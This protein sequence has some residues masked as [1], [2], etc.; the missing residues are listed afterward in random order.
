MNR[1]I[2]VLTVCTGN[3]CRSPLAAA[4][5]DR[6]LRGSGV[7]VLVQSAGT[8]AFEGHAPPNHMIE[9]ADQFDVDLRNVR[10]RSVTSAALTGADLVLCLAADHARHVLGMA[11][12]I[13][14]R[15][16]LLKEAARYVPAVHDSSVDTPRSST[17]PTAM[18]D[19]FV[20]WRA[21]MVG[22][23]DPMRYWSSES[24]RD[25]IPDPMGHR[26]QRYHDVAERVAF[27]AQLL[28]SRWPA[29]ATSVTGPFEHPV[30]Q[31]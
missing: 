30:F 6:H 14:D 13:V 22:S 16:L 9:A 3:L 23:R 24:L 5:L 8:G 7:R 4:L 27:F 2:R 25:D 10:S 1:A 11:P 29:E 19:E 20:E 26:P 31:R 17:G 18:S 28:V 21:G 15:T 12:E